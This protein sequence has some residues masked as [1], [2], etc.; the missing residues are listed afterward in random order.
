[1]RERVLTGRGDPFA[2]LARSG[3]LQY[4]VKGVIDNNV[5]VGELKVTC[6]TTHHRVAMAIG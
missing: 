5:V 3:N 1:V 2:R 6:V 4:P